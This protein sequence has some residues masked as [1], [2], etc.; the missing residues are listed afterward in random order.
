MT[1]P[2]LAPFAPGPHT[3]RRMGSAFAKAMA[4]AAVQGDSDLITVSFQ[5]S[6]I[7]P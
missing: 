4:D 2:N 6:P 5:G 1:P 3:T 7:L